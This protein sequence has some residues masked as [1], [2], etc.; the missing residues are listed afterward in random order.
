MNIKE[1]AQYVLDTVKDSAESNETDVNTEMVR[2]YLDCMEDCD[3]VSA[4]EICVFEGARAK[5]T[6]YDY[7]D[8]A[9]SLDLFLFIHSQYLAGRVDSRVQ[10]GFNY[11]REF[12][13]QCT[14]KK[15]PFSGDEHQ[16]E[17]E[18]Q[19][20]INIIREAKGKVSVIRF[21]LLTDGAISTSAETESSKDEE[22]EVIYEYRADGSNSLPIN[23][24]IKILYLIEY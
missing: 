3:E 16:F 23:I 11:L 24:L 20:A 4:P 18:V 13:N 21:Y 5:L 15:S 6:A 19:D 1:F 9:D 22:D 12:Y 17:G 14:K 7:N 2:C 8:E 10:T